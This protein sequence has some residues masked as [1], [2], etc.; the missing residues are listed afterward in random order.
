MK[1]IV[2]LGNPGPEYEAT[3]HNVGFWVI[4]AFAGT[5]RIALSEKKGEAKIGQGELSLPSGRTSFLLAKPQTFMNRS[6]RSVQRLLALFDISLPDLIV[7]YDDLDLECG[8]VRLKTKGRAGGH[9]GVA[10]IIQTIGSDEF[11][12]IKIGIGRDPRQDPAEYVLTPFPRD[13]KKRVLEGVEKG[14]ELLP[15]LLEGR[16]SEAMNRYHTA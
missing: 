12:R 13:D 9:R 3:K 2:G 6:G 7:V 5:H 4:D 15:L 8:R 14:V 10:S 11:I 16:I 1:L